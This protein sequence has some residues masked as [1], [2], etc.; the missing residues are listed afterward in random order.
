MEETRN[1]YKIL[2]G[3]SGRRP[4]HIWED[5]IKLC[6]KETWYG[7]R[8]GALADCSEQGN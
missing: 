8:K 7:L 2:V 4:V 3:K 6:I 1:V 5:N